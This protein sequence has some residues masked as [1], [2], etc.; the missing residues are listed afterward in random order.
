MEEIKRK[1]KQYRSRRVRERFAALASDKQEELRRT[2]VTSLKKTDTFLYSKHKKEGFDSRLVEMQFFTSM[3]DV[4]LI[5]SRGDE[6]RC[7]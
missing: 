6:L 2:F 7:V 3:S 5:Y 4:L 1:W